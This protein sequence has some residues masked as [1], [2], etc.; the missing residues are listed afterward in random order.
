MIKGKRVWLYLYSKERKLDV[1]ACR[2]LL[3]SKT[4]IR[5]NQTVTAYA[6]VSGC[7][8]SALDI[9]RTRYTR[10]CRKQQ[11]LRIIVLGRQWSMNHVAKDNVLKVWEPHQETRYIYIYLHT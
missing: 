7:N 9:A 1:V 3:A 4:P 5:Y 11:F 2:S 6:G 10:Q 8:S